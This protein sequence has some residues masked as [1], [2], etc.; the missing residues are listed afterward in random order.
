M[1]SVAAPDQETHSIETVGL[2][3]RVSRHRMVAAIASGFLLWTSFPPVEWSWL[4]WIA[5]VPLF[6]LATLPGPSSKTYLAAWA[7][8]LVFWL[9]ALE[10]VRL[11]D[12]S[13]WLGWLLMAL[14]F[15]L[16]WPGFLA[17]TRWAVFRLQLPLI[18]AAP[19]IW[20]G[21]EF[22]RAYF[23]SGFPWY[24]LAHSQFRRLY[25][26]QIADF[27]GSLGISFLIA[28]VNALVVDLLT[29]PLLHVTKTRN[30]ACHGASTSGSA[31]SRFSWVRPSA[32]GRSGSRP[33]RFAT[34]PSSRSC[35]PTSS[36]NTRAKGD[37]TKILTEFA[38]LV[39]RGRPPRDSRPDR[40]AGDRLSATAS[41]PS[42]PPSTMPTLER[43]VRSITDEDHR[44]RTGS[45]EKRRS[46][47]ELHLWA[48]TDQSPD[49]GRKH[50]L[51][52]PA[53][54]ARKVQLGDPL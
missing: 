36:K 1:T 4:A 51:R 10:W 46:T 50:L 31:W 8:G 27:T 47:D 44:S 5:L 45:R 23:L 2:G 7:G 22:L 49:A 54:L 20:V 39:Q 16:W 38:G 40:L 53:R 6:W 17:L 37:P 13:A 32:T 9:L 15:S 42:T 28:V 18:L 48:D 30:A 34:G 26:I 3:A 24:Y 21:G 25:L 33:P 19:I 14:V 41:S 29:L 11:S 43:Q 52:P 12:A 35:N